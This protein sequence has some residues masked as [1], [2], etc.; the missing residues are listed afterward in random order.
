MSPVFR[1]KWNLHLLS[2][3]LQ[4]ITPVNVLIQTL[5]IKA[6]TCIQLGTCFYVNLRARFVFTIPEH[7]SVYSLILLNK[8]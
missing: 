2:L 5:A 8:K 1:G 7:R 3:T 6:V 4:I